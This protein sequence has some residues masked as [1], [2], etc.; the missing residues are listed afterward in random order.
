[1]TKIY[2]DIDGVPVPAEECMWVVTAPCGCECSWSVASY[3][4]D[5][6]EVWN[7]FSRSK[8]KRR[9]DEKLGFRVQIKRHKD[10]RI[11]DNCPHTPRFGVDIPGLEGHTWATMPRTRVLHLVALVIEKGGTSPYSKVMV[12]SLCGRNEARIWSA[13]RW[14]MEG[15]VECA[16]C[17]KVAKERAA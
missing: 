17:L 4:K 1:M 15:L 12:P 10:I 13:D 14:D 2:F 16:H 11:S 6:D 9:R 3:C 8:A 5:E 7:N